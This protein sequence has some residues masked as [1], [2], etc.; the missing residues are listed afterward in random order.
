[1]IGWPAT[2]HTSLPSKADRIKTVF[3]VERMR[4]VPSRWAPGRASGTLPSGSGPLRLASGSGPSRSASSQRSGSCVPILERRA[5][6]RRLSGPGQPAALPP[7]LLP[8]PTLQI[9]W[10]QHVRGRGRLPARSH[11]LLARTLLTVDQAWFSLSDNSACNVFQ[12]ATCMQS[13]LVG[14]I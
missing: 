2:R 14:M 10:V 11:A 6:R 12:P 9:L 13:R 1:M 3:Q 7:G 8:W 4:A 5:V